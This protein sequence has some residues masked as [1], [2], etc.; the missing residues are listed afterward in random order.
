[1]AAKDPG[2]PGELELVQEDWDTVLKE[3]EE[4]LSEVEDPES[5]RAGAHKQVN[6]LLDERRKLFAQAIAICRKIR[7]GHSK[8]GLADWR[9]LQIQM[10]NCEKAIEDCTSVIHSLVTRGPKDAERVFRYKHRIDNVLVLIN[11]IERTIED[12]ERPDE[13]IRTLVEVCSRD[14]RKE[15][16]SKA[17]VAL[18]MEE[19]HKMQMS[20]FKRAESCSDADN[21]DAESKSDT[22][23]ERETDALSLEGHSASK[24]R[25]AIDKER[26][27]RS[28]ISC[29]TEVKQRQGVLHQ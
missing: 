22:I 9:Y 4:P 3:A 12:G 6:E 15:P 13:T 28:K 17:Q 8:L 23:L 16:S 10:K 1:M 25:A 24:A 5:I 19:A 11:I 29:Q 7:D 18:F 20:A 27:E 26:Q 14:I 21:E 2:N